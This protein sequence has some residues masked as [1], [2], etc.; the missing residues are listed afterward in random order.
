[1]SK[2]FIYKKNTLTSL[3]GSLAAL[4]LKRNLEEGQDI[5]IPSLSIVLSKALVNKKVP[6]LAE[7]C[8]LNVRRLHRLNERM[9][10]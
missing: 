5:E 9:H 8:L 2:V 4:F 6:L 1:M 3:S 10:D 7:G